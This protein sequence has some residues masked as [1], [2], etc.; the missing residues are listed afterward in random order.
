M[1]RYNSSG[2]EHATGGNTVNALSTKMIVTTARE[3]KKEI[4]EFSKGEFISYKEIKSDEHEVE[5]TLK[6][7]FHIMLNMEI[8]GNFMAI[9]IILSMN[10]NH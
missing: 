4:V 6:N 1:T 9:I 7:F 8:I 5:V 10:Q 2:G 3:G